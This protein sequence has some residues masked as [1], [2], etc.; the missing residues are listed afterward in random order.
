M[1]KNDSWAFGLSKWEDN[2]LLTEIYWYEETGRETLMGGKK[3]QS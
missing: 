2:S 1:I 3:I